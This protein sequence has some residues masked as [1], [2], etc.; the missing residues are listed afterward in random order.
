[1]LYKN[2]DGHSVRLPVNWSVDH[3]LQ[4]VINC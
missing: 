2:R 1:L 3:I 4:G